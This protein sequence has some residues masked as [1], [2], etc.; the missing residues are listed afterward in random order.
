MEEF[1]LSKKMEG[2]NTMQNAIDDIKEFN[3]ISSDIAKS[4]QLEQYNA[5]DSLLNELKRNITRRITF[6]KKNSRDHDLITLADM[7]E[8]LQQQI[9]YNSV[10]VQFKDLERKFN[11]VITLINQEELQQGLLKIK[12]LTPKITELLNKL[13]DEGELDFK[14]QKM[15]EEARTLEARLPEFKTK[16][17]EQYS[18]LVM[19]DSQQKITLPTFS[20]NLAMPQVIP[21]EKTD[22]IG[23]LI[24]SLDDQFTQWD[25]S[26]QQKTDKS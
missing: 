3:E 17:S 22:N 13:K 21:E 1:N 23:K 9:A 12:Y 4:Q 11:T 18:R 26:V 6:A 8:D 2:W 15:L 7:Q 5:I 19:G 25:K 10:F 24:E 20:S 16:I 14:Y